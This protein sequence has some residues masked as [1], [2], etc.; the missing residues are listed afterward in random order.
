LVIKLHGYV[1]DSHKAFPP[2]WKRTEL[3]FKLKWRRFGNMAWR[4]WRCNFLGE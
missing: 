4:K 3:N 1:K 2:K